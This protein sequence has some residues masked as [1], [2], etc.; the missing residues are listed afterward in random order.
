MSNNRKAL[1]SRATTLSAEKTEMTHGISIVRRL[2]N[3]LRRYQARRE[4]ASMLHS[5]DDRVLADI[6]LNRRQIDSAISPG[7]SANH[8]ASR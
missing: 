5:L 1:T 8:E 3:D 4:K 7:Q 2:W 6:G